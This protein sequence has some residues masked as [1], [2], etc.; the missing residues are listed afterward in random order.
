MRPAVSVDQQ[1]GYNF[2][3]LVDKPLPVPHEP[4]APD[5]LQD[6]ASGAMDG[7]AFSNGAFDPSFNA[8]LDFS[9]D[10]FIDD[11]A[12]VAVDYGAGAA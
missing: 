2:D 9:F 6:Y 3:F 5:F 12:I 11:S 10:D 4:P 1:G 8:P 7:F